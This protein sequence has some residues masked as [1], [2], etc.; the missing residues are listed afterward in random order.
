MGLPNNGLAL[1]LAFC[2]YDSGTNGVLVSYGHFCKASSS[3]SFAR[4]VA[5][6]SYITIQGDNFPFSIK[7][8]IEMMSGCVVR[9]RRV[10]KNRHVKDRL[11][12]L[13]LR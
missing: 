8:T 10:C 12:R 5:R 6:I 2:Y 11:I 9:L 3:N 7:R 1:A 13:M 4:R